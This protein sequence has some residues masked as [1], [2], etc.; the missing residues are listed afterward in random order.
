MH[1]ELA[2]PR[3]RRTRPSGGFTL[4]ELLVTVTI[5][6]LVIGALSGTLIAGL[7]VGPATNDRTRLAVDTSF[8]TNTL[9]DDIANASQPVAVADEGG[10]FALVYTNSCAVSFRGAWHGP[11]PVGPVT[12]VIA[13][14]EGATLVLVDGSVVVY[15]A[16]LRPY[17]H[18]YNIVEVLRYDGSWSTALRGYCRPGDNPV[19]STV[20]GSRFSWALT[21]ASTPGARAQRVEIGGDRRTV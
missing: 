5:M 14:V 13:L 19:V 17:D 21:L 16:V 18:E 3:R 10:L 15:Q 2:G 4:V 7:S 9:S 20:S 6:G 1:S 11:W 12:D 8:L